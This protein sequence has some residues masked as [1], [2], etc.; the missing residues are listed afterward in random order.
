MQQWLDV[1]TPRRD[2]TGLTVDEA[3][4]VG[5]AIFGP[6]LTDPLSDTLR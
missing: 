5:R 4:E 1:Q 2:G 3:L 6:V